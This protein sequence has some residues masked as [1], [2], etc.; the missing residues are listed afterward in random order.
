MFKRLFRKVNDERELLNMFSNPSQRKSNNM[1]NMN[2]MQYFFNNPN[3]IEQ[4]DFNN[5]EKVLNSTQYFN[6]NPSFPLFP[7]IPPQVNPYNFPNNL[8][9]MNQNMGFNPNQMMPEPT[10]MSYE[11]PQK[12]D[13]N[14]SFF[15]QNQ[16]PNWVVGQNGGLPN[17]VFPNGNNDFDLNFLK[18]RNIGFQNAVADENNQMKYGKVENMDSN[19]ENYLKNLTKYL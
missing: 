14:N 6:Q 3:S 7:G 2:N 12:N 15:Q 10:K 4:S 11:N 1:N 16:F 9:Q 18:N 8:P 5:F 19:M 13:E 17:G